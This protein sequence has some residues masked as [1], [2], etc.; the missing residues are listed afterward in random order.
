MFLCKYC[1]ICLFTAAENECKKLRIYR[2]CAIVT[3]EHMSLH[4]KKR[5]GGVQFNVADCIFRFRGLEI[6][7]KESQVV[8][9]IHVLKF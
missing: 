1:A 2:D 9:K 3:Q 6:F 8:H 7:E 4:S 5:G